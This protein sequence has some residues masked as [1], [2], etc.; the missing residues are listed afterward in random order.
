MNQMDRMGDGVIITK[1]EQWRAERGNRPKPFVVTKKVHVVEIECL[2]C[3]R[4]FLRWASTASAYGHC[5]H[6][7]AAH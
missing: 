5:E 1:L 7:S 4:R 6:C 2:H 3:H